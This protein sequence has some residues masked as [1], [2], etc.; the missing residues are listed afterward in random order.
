MELFAVCPDCRE[1]ATA[2]LT[3]I[4]GTAIHI[5][6]SCASCKFERSWCS[7]PYVGN[8]ALGNLLVSA[9]VLFTGS[10]IS[11]VL[12]LFMALK[13]PVFCK[14]TYFRHQRCYLEPT[15][16]NKWQSDQLSLVQKL[17][18]MGSGLVLAG[19]GRSDSPGYCAKFGTYSVLE[20]RVNKILDIQVVQVN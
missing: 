18:A 11:K 8:M 12:R 7:Q 19:D 17:K 3:R 14:Q 5:K 13:I 6:Q 10:L 4:N 9:A 15:V 16:H 2:Q 1:P 20:Q